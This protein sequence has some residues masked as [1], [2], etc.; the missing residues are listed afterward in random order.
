ML[1]RAEFLAPVVGDREG[2]DSTHVGLT[3]IRLYVPESALIGRSD[4]FAEVWILDESNERIRRQRVKLEDERREDYIRVGDGLRP[5]DRVVANPR[6][7]LRAGERV[8]F[9]PNSTSKG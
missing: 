6:P 2:M 7:D 3:K 5:G 4:S 8:A 1:C 9:A